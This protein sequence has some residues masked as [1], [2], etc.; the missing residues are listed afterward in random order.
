MALAEM[1]FAGDLGVE[2]QLDRVPCEISDGE[3]LS[4]DELTTIRLF[5]ESNSRF[6][7][8]VPVDQ[9]EAFETKL[10]GVPFAKIGSVTGNSQVVVRDTENGEALIDT[11]LREF[12]SAWLEP[13]N[14]N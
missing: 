1:A 13:L 7:V 9:S 3:S 4:E 14:W 11:P 12:K 10:D 5:A 6:L 8:E 2:V